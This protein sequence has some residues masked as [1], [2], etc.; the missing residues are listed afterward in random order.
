[1]AARE[2]QLRLH[3][4]VDI[5]GAQPGLGG[6]DFGLLAGEEPRHVHGVR[7]DVHRGA[8]RERVLVTDVVGPHE[9]EAK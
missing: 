8:A 3:R 1:M 7:A 4:A 9:R 5:G 6:D 2:A